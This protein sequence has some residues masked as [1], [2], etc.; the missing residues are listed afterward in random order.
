MTKE[1]G[2]PEEM[3]SKL[4]LTQNEYSETALHVAAE[5]NLA[6]LEKVWAY[7]QSNPTKRRRVNELLLATDRHGYTDWNRAAE[8]GSSE[9]L[10]TLCRY[11]K[12]RK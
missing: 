6:V 8:K 3:K 2:N 9:A 12:K 4:L 10:E 7:F 5:G 11:T 1:E